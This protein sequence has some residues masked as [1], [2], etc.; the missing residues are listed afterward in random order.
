[1]KMIKALV[2]IDAD[3]P[4]SIALRYTC[5]L[6]R[7][8][9]MEIQTIHV[10]DQT[11]A[12]PGIGAGWARH[13]WEKELVEEGKKEI[14]QLLTAESGFCAILNEPIVVPGDHEKEILAELGGG[15][16]DLFVEGLPLTSSTNTLVKR[17]KSHLYQ[18]ISTPNLLVQNLF[19]LE[20]VTLMVADEKD[21]SLLIDC[22]SALFGSLELVLD[23]ILLAQGEL[24]HLEGQSWKLAKQHKGRIQR[25][26]SS[27]ETLKIAAQKIESGGLIATVLERS[28]KG[29][30]PLLEFLAH[31]H[32]PL[33][34]CWK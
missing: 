6:A 33:L 1:M 5:Q 31:A 12:G 26:F 10:H 4:S 27:T 19:P 30:N 20:H 11:T 17:M 13:T 28:R 16:Y 25:G 9:E 7:R 34:F 8:I 3:L 2:S 29:G 32:C 18:Q 21:L 22:F 23:A 14:S 15:S 24:K